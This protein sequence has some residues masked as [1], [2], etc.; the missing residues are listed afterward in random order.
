[1]SPIQQTAVWQEPVRGGFPPPELFGLTGLEQMR[2][3]VRGQTPRPPIHHLT[4]LRPTE[5]DPGSVTFA[6]PATPWLL[7]PPGVI[8]GGVLAVLADAPLGSAFHS[9]LPPATAYTTSELSMSFL[10]PATP[11]SGTLVARGRLIHAGRSLGL[12]EVTLQ[13]ENG[14]LLAHGTSRCV[15]FPPVSPAP[16]PPAAP[17]PY[18]PPAH[19][20]P[21]PYLRPVE[22]EVLPQETW[23]RTDGLSI[24]E[25]LIGGELPPPP[26]S[27]LTGLRPVEVSE[28]RATFVLPASGWLCSPAGTVEGGFIGLLADTAMAGAVQ[29][30][31]PAGTAFAT[32]DLKVN[33]LRPVHPDGRDL[34]GRGSVL[35]R[36]RRIA[37]ARAELE[38]ADGKQVALATG[39]AMILSGRPVNLS[40]PVVPEDE[41]PEG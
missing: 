22:G 1:M 32:L 5:A 19:D 21:D 36:G 7:S 8:Q 14:R 18:E 23:D 37:V 40:R 35:H 29:T 25:A 9:V 15:V 34:V 3:F 17:A 28:G 41:A 6:M 39:S 16:D 20:T 30:T 12:T 11:E 13:D 38:N 10:R 31:V 2:S 4:G 26:I 27:R 33:F 24:L